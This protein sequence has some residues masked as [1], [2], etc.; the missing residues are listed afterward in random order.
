[1]RKNSKETELGT[2]NQDASQSSVKN[3]GVVLVPCRT[4]K[5][6]AT[7]ISGGV[8]FL[9]VPLCHFL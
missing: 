4:W 3:C 9:E 5:C 6:V 7:S 8:N 1:M 2:S